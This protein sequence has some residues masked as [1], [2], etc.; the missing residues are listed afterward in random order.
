MIASVTG[1]LTHKSPRSLVVD[2]HGIG[3][4][5]SISL[6]TFYKLPDIRE[7]ITL[8]TVTH[9]SDNTLQLY[10]FRF[11]LEREVFTRLMT[12]SGVGPRSAL[13]ILSCLPVGDLVQAIQ[14]DDVQKLKS[15][16]GIGAKTAGRI[17]LELKDKLSGLLEQAEE[18][19]TQP[20][21]GR[22]NRQALDDTLSAL[23]N[24]GYPRHEARGAIQKVQQ[25]NA[26]GSV[27]VEDLIR[28]TLKILSAH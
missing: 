11:P 8:H 25:N 12:I 9:L 24:L 19:E 4:Q 20:S 23:L 15:V 7:Q 2:V 28:S 10:G 26:D 22:Q 14:D 18:L 16:R 5:L 6:Q 27:G 3:Y 21:A 1:T 13:G 17:A